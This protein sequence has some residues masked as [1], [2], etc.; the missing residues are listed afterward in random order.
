MSPRGRLPRREPRSE[1]QSPRSERRHEST[2]RVTPDATRIEGQPRP[3]D[4]GY[5]R[6]GAEAITQGSQAMA[7][8]GD[9]RFMPGGQYADVTRGYDRKSMDR[10][11]FKDHVTGLTERG[12][13]MD[14][15]IVGRAMDSSFSSQISGT[16]ADAAMA[17]TVGHGLHSGVMRMA[18]K[19]IEAVKVYM[20]ERD[21]GKGVI[22]SAMASVSTLQGL[23]DKTNQASVNFLRDG[24]DSIVDGVHHLDRQGQLG[25]LSADT[26]MSMGM[27]NNGPIRERIG[28]DPMKRADQM[29]QG[30]PVP[31]SVLGPQAGQESPGG[32]KLPSVDK[33]PTFSTFGDRG[34]YAGEKSAKLP[35]RPSG[36]GVKPS[37]SK[38]AAQEVEAP[39][40]EAPKPNTNNDSLPGGY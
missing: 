21:A 33:Q 9:P 37:E 5:P 30:M 28:F 39:Q 34:A 2:Q 7:G 19:G 32:W 11:S 35:T 26:Y 29:R 13:N 10:G 31:D 8:M 23:S 1:P 25:M 36:L 17:E 20:N 18:R 3:G 14:P 40:I 6:T 16:L 4:F 27:L 22:G 15:R 24:R 38:S 12:R